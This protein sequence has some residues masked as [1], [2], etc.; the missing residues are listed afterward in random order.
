MSLVNEL[1]SPNREFSF[2]TADV[3]VDMLPADVLSIFDLAKDIGYLP[4]VSFREG[5]IRTFDYWK[6]SE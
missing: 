5:I 4:E 3:C 2:G 6:T 1:I